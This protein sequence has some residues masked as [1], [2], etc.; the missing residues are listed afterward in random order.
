MAREDKPFDAYNYKK[1]KEPY[2]FI[3]YAHADSARVY[4]YIRRLHDDGFRI[5]YD[6]GIPFSRDWDEEV[7]NALAGAA[8][9]VL[10]ISPTSVQRPN[11]TRELKFASDKNK[12]IMCLYLEETTLPHVWQFRLGTS[13]AVLDIDASYSKLMGDLDQSTRLY[14][15]PAPLSPIQIPVKPPQRPA[16]TPA[17]PSKSEFVNGE[18]TNLYEGFGGRDWLVL[19]VD[20]QE[21]RAL[22]LSKDVVEQQPYHS[23]GGSVTWAEC[24][25]PGGNATD[26]Y[27]FLLSVPE[28]LK[29][30]PGLKLNKDSSGNELGYEAD[31]RLVAK[32]NNGGCWWWLRSPG[33]TA[34]LAAY[35]DAGGV[36][37][38][39]GRTVYN[40][41][42]GV[43]P[44]LWLNFDPVKTS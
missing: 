19:D 16:P 27:I 3:S 39:Y 24:S 41:S 15:P 32:F 20:K 1:W 8:M 22:L 25:L 11:V 23:G 9:M 43:R 18:W 30:F 40:T 44:A 14:V 12:P 36:V 34:D 7:A 35:V 31:E 4:P 6:E 38:L 26:D 42:G 28:I 17:L 13:Q 29:Y 37:D 2:L 21:N 5:W 33:F 10:F